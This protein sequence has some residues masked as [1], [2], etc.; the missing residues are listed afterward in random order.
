MRLLGL[1]FTEQSGVPSLGLMGKAI[2]GYSRFIM[3]Y[4]CKLNVLVQS[5]LNEATLNYEICI[6]LALS[7][8]MPALLLPTLELFID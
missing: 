3:L 2:N 7:K 6:V 1:P 8:K 5:Y 4:K